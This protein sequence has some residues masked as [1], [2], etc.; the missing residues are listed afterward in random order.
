MHFLWNQKGGDSRGEERMEQRIT[1]H[2]F[3]WPPGSDEKHTSLISVLC[4]KEV[5]AAR[6]SSAMEILKPC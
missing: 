2:P 6:L 3:I 1:S 4:T 5:L